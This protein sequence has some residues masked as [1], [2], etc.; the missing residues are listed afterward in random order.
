M[1]WLFF[2][3]KLCDIIRTSRV[4]AGAQIDFDTELESVLKKRV[5]D[6]DDD[7]DGDT[8]AKKII[9]IKCSKLW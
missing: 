8:F 6:D 1:A 9:K 7:H 2:V 4:A 3:N 5:I